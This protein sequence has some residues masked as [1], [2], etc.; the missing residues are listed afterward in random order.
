[1][2]RW[3][4]VLVV[5]A[6]ALHACGG[7]SEPD[8]N[9]SEDLRFE[10]GAT[11]LGGSGILPDLAVAS[12][13]QLHLCYRGDPTRGDNGV[14]YQFSRSGSG[15]WSS[16]QR[17]D[18]GGHTLSRSLEFGT[19]RIAAAPSG[20]AT[21]VWGEFPDPGNRVWARDI[22][23]DGTPGGFTLVH[24][25]RGIALEQH[26]VAIDQS[27][28]AHL[29]IALI[30]NG[31]DGIYHKSRQQNGAWEGGRRRI[32]SAGRKHPVIVA[33]PGPGASLWAAWRFRD[34]EYASFQGNA[35]GSVRVVAAPAGQSIG[36]PAMAVGTDG[37]PIIG[38]APFR[39]GISNRSAYLHQE[40]AASPFLQI[41]PETL[42][43]TGTVSLALSG[44]KRGL[45]VWDRFVLGF[46]S[47]RHVISDVNSLDLTRG[48]TILNKR[49]VCY[50]LSDSEGR[51][52]AI[53]DADNSN[54]FV[55]PLDDGLP[56]E[57]GYAAVEIH[58]SEVEMVYVETSSTGQPRL[59]HRRAELP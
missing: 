26:D 29:A 30:G 9:D 51:F 59:F 11:S 3:M 42:F 32:H 17:L 34:L 44:S 10:G 35:W 49:R 56:S 40:G 58:G 21:V 5:V 4:P 27:G 31:Q 43:S 45:F 12:G 55:L 16:P 28:T 13:G 47:G 38:T 33:S 18:D 52:P 23:T 50:K 14:Y 54:A 19:P 6:M 2:K 15:S 39:P 53:P 25:E 22:G 36:D 8:G 7:P 41:D 46:R 1:M 37:R 20:G 24:S 48:D 57:Q